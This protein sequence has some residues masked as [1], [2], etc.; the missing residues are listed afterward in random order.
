MLDENPAIMKA[1]EKLRTTEDHFSVLINEAL[2]NN[3]NYE[4]EFMLKESL[5][6]ATQKTALQKLSANM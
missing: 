5:F 1:L 2:E 3:I 4:R 6:L